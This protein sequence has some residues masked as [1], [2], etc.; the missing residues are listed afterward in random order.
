MDAVTSYNPDERE[1]VEV[2]YNISLEVEVND[3]NKWKTV[4][5]DNGTITIKQTLSQDTADYPGQLE[6]LQ[7]YC[8]FSNP[9]GYSLIGPDEFSPG[10]PY[11]YPYTMVTGFDGI[12]GEPTTRGDDAKNEP[13]QKGDIWYDP[14]SNTRRYYLGDDQPT[15]VK[16]KSGKLGG[17]NTNGGSG[18][19]EDVNVSTVIQSP[20]LFLDPKD[21]EDKKT[22][23][24]TCET[25]DSNDPFGGRTPSG[26]TVDITEVENGRII[27]AEVNQPGSGYA[28]GDIVVVSSG[29]N[30]GFLEIE[31]Q[32]KNLW[33][34]NYVPPGG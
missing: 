18:Y 30:N 25:L 2:T 28:E 7:R 11:T 14:K 22:L 19:K 10:Y 31:I 26:L 16:V 3:N 33:T 17:L 12:T 5:L 24:E 29:R 1:S 4:D 6:E 23:E 27:Q 9:N 8:N 15:N 34:E 32:T 13:L 20:F 21:L